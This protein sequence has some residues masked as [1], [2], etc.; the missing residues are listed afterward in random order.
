MACLAANDRQNVR[1]GEGKG[2][3]ADRQNMLLAVMFVLLLDQVMGDTRSR[4]AIRTSFLWFGRHDRKCGHECMNEFNQSAKLQSNVCQYKV[5]LIICKS[6]VR[7][8]SGTSSGTGI[9][10]RLW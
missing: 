10:C 2:R 6:G 8:I 3:A 9:I 7:V 1:N 4:C 5:C